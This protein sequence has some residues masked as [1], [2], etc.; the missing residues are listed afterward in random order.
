MDFHVE[1]MQKQ[2][3]VY[4]RNVGPYGLGNKEL[5]ENLKAWAAEN[6]LFH[7]SAEILGIA[8]DDPALTLPERCRY[9]ACIV[10]KEDFCKPDDFVREDWLFGGR[11]AVFTLAHTVEALREAW[12]SVFPELAVRGFMVDA[13]RPILERYVPRMVENH[14]CEICVPVLG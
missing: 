6:G 1:V 10:V 8:R 5:M 3:I 2:R 13:A 4:I 9:D 7:T 11:Y 12:N 14:L